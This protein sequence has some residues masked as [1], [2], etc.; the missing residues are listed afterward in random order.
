MGCCDDQNGCKG[1]VKKR[2][3]WFTIIVVGLAIM[4]AINWQ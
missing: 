3:P 2:I 4:V 1:K